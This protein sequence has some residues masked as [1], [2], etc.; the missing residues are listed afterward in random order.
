M[1]FEIQ[2]QKIQ[3]NGSSTFTFSGVI[4]Q[5]MYGI[6]AFHFEQSE[7][8]TGGTV[9]CTN[10]LSTLRA[11]LSLAEGTGVLN[12][13]TSATV[14][15]QVE[16]VGAGG[17]PTLWLQVTVVAWI[18]TASKVLLANQPGL[19]QSQL[20]APTAVPGGGGPPLLNTGALAGFNLTFA[21]GKGHAITAAGASVGAVVN[22]FSNTNGVSAVGSVVFTGGGATGPCTVDA[23]LIAFTSAQPGVVVGTYSDPSHSSGSTPCTV[24]T[25]SSAAVTAVAV[26]V[27]SFFVQEDLS[28]YTNPP[29]PMSYLEIGASNV[30][31]GA[32]GSFSFTSTRK[33]MGQIMYPG[34]GGGPPGFTPTWAPT[35]T[36]TYTYL[37]LLASS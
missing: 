31:G 24:S 22:P 7:Q 18:G 13:S 17:T 34:V 35:N 30:Q 27:Q 11:S 2:T 3:A 29:L 12:K 1:G 28:S 20:S 26:F 9:Y 21:D 36:I 10:N 8:V 5:L 32:N 14:M 16:M 6:T 15:A 19:S 23:A 25:G 37:A 33:M 4:G